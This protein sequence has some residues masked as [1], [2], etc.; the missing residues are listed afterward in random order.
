MDF[1]ETFSTMW[2]NFFELKKK[3]PQKNFEL[4]IFF[5][6]FWVSPPSCIFLRERFLDIFISILVGEIPVMVCQEEDRGLQ[7]LS[8]SFQYPFKNKKYVAG[9]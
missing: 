3:I 2:I 6:N 8:I 1:S 9:L 4:K 5:Q 7:S